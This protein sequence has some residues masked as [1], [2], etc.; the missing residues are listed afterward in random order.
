MSVIAR[1]DSCGAIRWSLLRVKPGASARGT[2]EICG[3]ELKVERRRPGRRFGRAARE[4]R[5]MQTPR[6]RA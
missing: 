6:A 1:C 3:G 4:R 2:C 5:D